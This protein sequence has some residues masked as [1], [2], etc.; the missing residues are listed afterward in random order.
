MCRTVPPGSE[1]H[2][3]KTGR[4]KGTRTAQFLREGPQRGGVGGLVG[5]LG[6]DLDV[7]GV[8]VDAAR[9]GVAR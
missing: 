5:A 7:V 8:E 3:R 1:R 2:D 6:I 4:P 9:R